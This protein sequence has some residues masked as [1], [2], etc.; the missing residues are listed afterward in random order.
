VTDLVKVGAT[1]LVVVR[2]EH[3][4]N[5]RDLPWVCGGCSPRRDFRKAVSRWE[6][7]GRCM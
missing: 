4:A 7:S 1:N 3:P 6:F 2:A 5:I